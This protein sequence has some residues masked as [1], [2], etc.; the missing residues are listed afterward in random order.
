[1]E[2]ER[3]KWAG[4]VDYVCHLLGSSHTRASGFS[5]ATKED[6]LKAATKMALPDTEDK[7]MARGRHSPTVIVCSSCAR[8]FHATRLPD[9]WSRGP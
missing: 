8:R 3:K 2:G 5:T 7:Q 9:G 6:S 4:K 1:M